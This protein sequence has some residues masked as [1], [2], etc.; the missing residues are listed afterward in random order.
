MFWSI[1]PEGRY[2]AYQEPSDFAVDRITD[3]GYTYDRM[4]RTLTMPLAHTNLAGL[5]GASN[6]TIGYQAN[7][8]VASLEQTVPIG[9]GTALRRQSFTLDAS[10]RISQ[11]VTQTNGVALLETLNHYDSASD[12]PAWTQTKTRPDGSS[13]YTA[14][15][16]RYVSDLAGALAIDV[17]DKGAAIL[18]LAN[19]HGDIVA[20]AKLGQPG[21]TQYTETDE[22]G[23]PQATGG[24]QAPRYGW[25][26][27]HQRD[28]GSVIGGLALMGVRLYAPATGRFLSIDPTRGGTE[29]RYTY[30]LDPINN[31]DISGAAAATWIWRHVVLPGLMLK[32]LARG[33]RA[34]RAFARNLGRGLRAMVRATGGACYSTSSGLHVCFGGS[35]KSILNYTR[36]AG[37][38]TYGDTFYTYNDPRKIYGVAAYR[39]LLKHES[40]HMKQWMMFG[41]DFAAMYAGEAWYSYAL[42][43]SYACQNW[44]EI[45][46]GLLNGGYTGCVSR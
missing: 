39:R 24:S 34:N 45:Q 32:A 44:F 28:S 31:S 41:R 27:T 18:Q 25:L 11:S 9:A 6:L 35:R 15:W 3:A 30:P 26:G 33:Q 13:A 20:T 17:D 38:T 16:N 43:R 42:T 22:Y 1:P 40:A 46:A 21:I 37:G 2:D 12:N 5:A 8:M 14:T 19:P 23:R 4:G 10:G 7:D 29:N 36:Q